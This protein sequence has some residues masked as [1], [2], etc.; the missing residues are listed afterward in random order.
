MVPGM[1]LGQVVWSWMPKHVKLALLYTI[2][3]LVE[4]HVDRFGAFFMDGFI[5]NVASSGFV[6]L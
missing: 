2:F 1:I 5:G 6:V 3:K 4:T